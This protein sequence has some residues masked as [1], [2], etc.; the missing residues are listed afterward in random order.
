MRL[1]LRDAAYTDRLAAFLR[2]VGQEPAVSAPDTL[3]VEVDP[4]E[5]D[6]YLRVWQVLHPDADV[7]VQA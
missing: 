4:A 6:V 2:S 3:E 5:L 1:Q 7:T